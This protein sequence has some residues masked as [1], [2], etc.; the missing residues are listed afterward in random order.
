MEGRNSRGEGSQQG[1]SMTLG[2]HSHIT[3]WKG[4]GRSSDQPG[5]TEVRDGEYTIS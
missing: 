3:S 2:V 5:V 4:S 1:A